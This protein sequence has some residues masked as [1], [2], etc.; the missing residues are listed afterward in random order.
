MH[1]IWKDSL[2][3]Y[4]QTREKP[5]RAKMQSMTQIRCNDTNEKR[6]TEK[7]RGTLPKGIRA[8]KKR[9]SKMELTRK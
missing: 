9:N 2:K 6:Q 4:R 5:S 1:S 7:A 3:E 8:S